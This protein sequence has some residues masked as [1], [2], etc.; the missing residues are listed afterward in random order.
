MLYL[1]S[2]SAFSLANSNNL[3]SI[4][5][6]S[7]SSMIP[8]LKYSPK[9]A[10]ILSTLSFTSFISKFISSLKSLKADSKSSP[11]SLLS[12]ILNPFSLSNVIAPLANE[13]EPVSI[14]IHEV[15]ST[16]DNT[17]ALIIS[18]HKVPVTTSEAFTPWLLIAV[19]HFQVLSTSSSL[20]INI[21]EVPIAKAPN[22]GLPTLLSSNKIAYSACGDSIVSNIQPI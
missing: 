5:F 15:P 4:A 14:S 16:S 17:P 13:N 20:L 12:I 21:P 18:A 3:E 6:A 9:S 1:V 19:D 10:P 7:T 2:T 22:K 11:V 8:S